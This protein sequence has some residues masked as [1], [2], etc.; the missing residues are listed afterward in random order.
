MENTANTTNETWRNIDMQCYRIKICQRVKKQPGRKKKVI[1]WLSLIS[2]AH[3]LKI[4]FLQFSHL[5]QISHVC[6]PCLF[7]F[8]FVFGHLNRSFMRIYRLNKCLVTANTDLKKGNI[9]ELNPRSV[10]RDGM[11]PTLSWGTKMKCKK[12]VWSKMTHGGIKLHQEKL[13]FQKSDKTQKR[14][15]KL[16]IKMTDIGV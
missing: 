9:Q 16:Y 15:K 8:V 6:V 1:S 5:I 7:D 11:K 10:I 12:A 4:F 2:C 3:K 14:Q 13:R